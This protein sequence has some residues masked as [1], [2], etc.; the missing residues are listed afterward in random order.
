MA[1][2]MNDKS[3]FEKCVRES[4]STKEA[5]FRLGYSPP[6]NYYTMFKNYVKKHNVDVSHF[7]SRGEIIKNARLLNPY[8]KYEFK[9][10]FIENFGGSVSSNHLK[11]K[12]YKAGL[13]TKKCEFCGQDENWSFGKI[14]MIL[15]HI[16]GNHYDNRVENL[17]ILC[18]NCD[19][20]LPTYKAK[21]KKN[22]KENNLSQIKRIEKNRNGTSKY[23]LVE[24]F[25]KQILELNLDKS[26]RG[27]K[28]KISKHMKWSPT[29]TNNFIK[30]YL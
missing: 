12:L 23:V 28:A 7:I 3:N 11:E 27:W 10:I 29:F 19:S 17:R 5:I 2:L 8:K 22:K 21:N 15:D 30:K 6:T 20:T 4:K 1:N 13:K 14:P 26:K 18:P 9:D 16:N 25:K 24:N